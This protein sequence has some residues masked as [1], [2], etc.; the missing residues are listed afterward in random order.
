MLKPLRDR[1]DFQGLMAVI[2]AKRSKQSPSKR[3]YKKSLLEPKVIEQYKQ[4][5]EQLMQLQKP[6]EFGPTT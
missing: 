4:Q 6:Y 3:K 2:L 1:E 5:L